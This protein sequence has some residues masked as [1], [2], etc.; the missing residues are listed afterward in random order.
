MTSESSI[1]AVLAD[2][3]SLARNALRDALRRAGV[4]VVGQAADT[5]QAINL[6]SR[7]T[8]DVV[9]IDAVLPPGGAIAALKPA[10]A[11]HPD[12]DVIVL[13]QSGE[14]DAGL[15]M[16]VQ[17][18]ADTSPGRR[19]SVALLERSRACRRV[20]RRSRAR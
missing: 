8:P 2:G 9:V 12:A 13:A 10:I 15:G 1:R 17:G 11:A 16:L 5:H 3:D 18:A 7:C 6:V 14:D 20:K 4:A 19:T